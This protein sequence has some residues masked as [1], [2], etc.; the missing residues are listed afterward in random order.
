ME[1]C[2]WELSCMYYTLH[3][4]DSTSVSDRLAS[5]TRYEHWRWF[6]LDLLLENVICLHTSDDLCNPMLS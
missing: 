3:V 1:R 4:Y 2:K 6:L 5:V